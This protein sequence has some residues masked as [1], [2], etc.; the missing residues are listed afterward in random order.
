MLENS[1][2]VAAPDGNSVLSVVLEV[3]AGVRSA[4][5]H[6][7]GPGCIAS[8]NLSVAKPLLLAPGQPVL[9]KRGWPHRS[10]WVRVAL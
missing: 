10:L 6:R 3:E 4:P 1:A 8:G 9:L 5:A 7:Y 2:Y